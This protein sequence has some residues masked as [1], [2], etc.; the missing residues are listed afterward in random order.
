MHVATDHQSG[1][2]VLQKLAAARVRKRSCHLTGKHVQSSSNLL[3]QSIASHCPPPFA[4][5]A[6]NPCEGRL[7]VCRCQPQVSGG[8]TNID[9]LE[10]HDS[11]R[12]PQ[13]PSFSSFLINVSSEPPN[14]FS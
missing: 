7:F 1:H 14:L 2:H 6:V 5:S 10:G 9:N 4:F 8:T 3:R 11:R 12:Y 13:G